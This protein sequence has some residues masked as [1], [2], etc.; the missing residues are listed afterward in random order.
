M[1]KTIRKRELQILP[2]GGRQR[3]ARCVV[4]APNISASRGIRY[5]LDAHF[6]RLVRRIELSKLPCGG[7]EIRACLGGDV[8]GWRQIPVSDQE[9]AAESTVGESTCSM[10]GDGTFV[11]TSN[12]AYPWLEGV[13]A[14]FLGAKTRLCPRGHA[15]HLTYLNIPIYARHE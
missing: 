14:S 1:R 9:V 15:L 3:N 13:L 10:M 11:A 8:A 12:K 4:H 6:Q 7:S 5:K 2:H